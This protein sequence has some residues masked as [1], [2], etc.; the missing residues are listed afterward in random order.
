MR[1][2]LRSRVP[3][4]LVA[5]L[6]LAVAGVGCGGDGGGGD[7]GDAKALLE[8]AFSK[9]VRSG[10]LKLDVKAD[11]EGG[12][13]R[14]EKPITLRLSGPYDFS[15][16]RKRPPR[17]DWDVAF[18]GAGLNVKGGLIATADNAFVELQGQAYEVGT[19]AFSSLA[20]QYTS[21]QPGRPQSVGAL[22]LDPASW[23]EDP[24]L[25]EDGESI[26]GDATRKVT[27]SVDVRRVAR[28]IVDLT[29]SPRL[30]RQLER[31]GQPVPE[32]PKPSKKD[33]DEIEQAIDKFEVEVNVDRNDVVR[34]FFTEFDFDVPEQ[35]DGDDLKGGRVSLSYVLTEVNTEPVIRAPRNAKPLRQLLEGFGLGGLGG[36]LG[37]P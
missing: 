1:A 12:G 3:L 37:G 2:S 9:Q 34:R 22:G 15:E 29:R 20:R 26:G 24:Q 16:G 32:I 8:R 4:A 25:D 11:L 14:L 19:E 35:K 7:S 31:Q 33:L 10:D 6:S 30:R 23:L 21:F 36:G 28:D 18:K 17:L 27:G 5:A 13:E